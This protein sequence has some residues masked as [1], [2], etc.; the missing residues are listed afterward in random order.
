MEDVEEAIAK[1]AVDGDLVAG[2]VLRGAVD[3]QP[4]GQV[5]RRRERGERGELVVCTELG[6]SRLAL[7][8]PGAAAEAR[9]EHARVV[10]D[11]RH[12][13]HVIRLRQHVRELVQDLAED[14]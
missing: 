6:R 7:K 2:Q 10:G 8:S 13:G 4:D 9:G 14:A 11:G 5:R 1:V 3:H 12:E